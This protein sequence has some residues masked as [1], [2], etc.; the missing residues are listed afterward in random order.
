MGLSTRG[1]IDNPVEAKELY[2][3]MVVLKNTKGIYQ[4]ETFGSATVGDVPGFSG[5][6]VWLHIKGKTGVHINSISEYEGVENEVLFGTEHQ[7]RVKNVYEKNG[8]YHVDLVE[9]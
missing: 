1:L 3:R 8:K 5:K 2:D 7:F 6:D 4:M 9:I